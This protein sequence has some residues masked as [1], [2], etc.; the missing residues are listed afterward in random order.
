M[1]RLAVDEVLQAVWGPLDCIGVPLGH[2]GCGRFGAT[3]IEG[4]LSL[5]ALAVLLPVSVGDQLVYGCTRTLGVPVGPYVFENVDLAVEWPSSAR[6]VDAVGE[7][8]RAHPQRRPHAGRMGDSGA[9]LEAAEGPAQVACHPSS[10]V[11]PSHVV[12]VDHARVPLAVFEG[13]FKNQCA[14]LDSYVLRGVGV[15]LQT[16]GRA[17]VAGEDFPPGR[18]D[19]GAVEV[20][21]PHQLQVSGCRRGR[22]RNL[23]GRSRRGWRNRR[24]RRD[25]CWWDRGGRGDWS[26]RR[27]DR[28]AR[29]RFAEPIEHHVVGLT[30]AVGNHQRGLA[31]HVGD[32]AGRDAQIGSSADIAAREGEPDVAFSCGDRAAEIGGQRRWCGHR[33]R[34]HR[35][36]QAEKHNERSS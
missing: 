4:A 8:D 26:W 10:G 23:G 17:V 9:D 36:E 32:P 31:G 19:G 21:A 5:F 7:V 22:S 25:W 33:Q 24:S 20:V 3:Q 35:R 1:V 11:G 18:I 28:S 2:E 6:I 27:W 30:H 15:G 34:D 14:V 29:H 13:G 12:G 16:V